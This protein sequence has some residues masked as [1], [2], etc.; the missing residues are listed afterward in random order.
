MSLKRRVAAHLPFRLTN[1]AIYRR[2]YFEQVDEAQRFLYS[3]LAD[4]L[5]EHWRPQSVIDVGCGTGFLLARLAEKGVAVQGIDGSRNAIKASP[6]RERIRRWNLRRPLPELGRFDLVICTEVAEHLPAQTAPTLVSGLVRLSDRILF[7]A[8][9]PGQTGRHHLNEQAH[10]Y[11]EALFRE[12]GF[13]RSGADETHLH[14]S[15][16]DID[17][18][19]WIHAN[20]MVYVRG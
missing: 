17:Q 1:A 7:T 16:A 4:V 10:S 12:R 14:K 19:P 2:S 8:A 5:H 18:A 6:I 13:V 15:I 11:W 9:T 3:R 20:L